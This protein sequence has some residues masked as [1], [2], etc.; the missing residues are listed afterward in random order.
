MGFG[1]SWQGMVNS[2]VGQKMKGVDTDFANRAVAGEIAARDAG[3]G[4]NREAAMNMNRDQL[5]KRLSTEAGL[6][7]TELDKYGRRY[8]SVMS[9]PEAQRERHMGLLADDVA[10]LLNRGPAGIGKM[11]L[12]E[13][14]SSQAANNRYVRRGAYPALIAGGTVAGGAALTEW[15]QQLMSLM[16]Y[17][18]ESEATEQRVEQSPLA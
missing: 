12:L 2:S 17:M 3:I 10:P 7:T 5:I 11:G 14:L 15:A 8:D 13:G 18:N 9:R 4:R 6:D 1:N 16:A